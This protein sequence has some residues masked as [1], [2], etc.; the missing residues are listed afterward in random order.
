MGDW[1]LTGLKFSASYR[2]DFVKATVV[3]DGKTL[4]VYPKD[5]TEPYQPQLEKIDGHTGELFYF[6]N[7][8]L[9]LSENTRN[10]ASGAARSVRLIEIMRESAVAAGAILPVNEQSFA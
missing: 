8:I 2:V 5:G 10:P 4:V 6:C 7:V 9:G 3:Y 1:T